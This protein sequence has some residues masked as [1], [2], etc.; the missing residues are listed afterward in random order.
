M[1]LNTLAALYLRCSGHQLFYGDSYIHGYAAAWSSIMTMTYIQRWSS[2][3]STLL[4]VLQ[5][6]DKDINKRPVVEYLLP[7]H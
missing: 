1:L 6:T 7:S 5:S 4:I 2:P 3:T